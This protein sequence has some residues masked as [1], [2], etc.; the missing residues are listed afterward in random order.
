M[1]AKTR[2]SIDDEQYL[3]CLLRSLSTGTSPSSLPCLVDVRIKSNAHAHKMRGG[4]YEADGNYAGIRM[5][6]T[7]IEDAS[8]LRDAYTRMLDGI[9]LV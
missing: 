5:F 6:F 7:N 2:R 3:Q 9:T 4:G 8:C 1:G